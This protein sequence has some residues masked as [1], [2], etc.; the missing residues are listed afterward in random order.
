MKKVFALLGAVGFFF[1]CASGASMAVRDT[2]PA[3]VEQWETGRIVAGSHDGALVVIGVSSRLSRHE[4]EIEAARNNA[5]RKVAMFHGM[6]G[7][8]RFI[9]RTGGNVLDFIAESEIDITL[10]NADYTRFA[11]RLTF[12]PERDVLRFEG[13]GILGRGGT[14]VRFRDAARVPG[15]SVAGT[16]DAE[17]RPGWISNRDLPDIDGYTVA[18]GFS[19]NQVWLRDTVMLATEN[20]A[21]R[22]ITGTE[23]VVS[24]TTV[25]VIGQAAFTYVT[26]VSSGVLSNFRILEFWVDPSN[27]SVYALGIARSEPASRS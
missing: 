11:E 27:M 5:A 24:T 20:V 12:D 17:G 26:S 10:A 21:A 9:N 22:L 23:S 16:V 13:K 2:A 7:T 19:R 25:E 8:A 18:V 14:L 6:N 15:V 4:D 3:L 1:A